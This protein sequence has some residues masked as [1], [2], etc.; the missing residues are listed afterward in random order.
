VVELVKIFGYANLEGE[1]E[2]WHH[3]ERGKEWVGL[4]VERGD[5]G[6]DPVTG[7]VERR[8]LDSGGGALGKRRTREEED[9]CLVG[10][11]GP[12]D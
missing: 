5:V 7:G 9:D 10:L 1:M 6:G 8:R 3:Y 2:G 12:R 11:R 4:G